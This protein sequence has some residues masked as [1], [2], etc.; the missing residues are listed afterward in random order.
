MIAAAS[1]GIVAMVAVSAAQ[2]FNFGNMMNPSRWFNDRDRD[3]D[4]YGGYG[5]YGYGGGPYGW[6]GPYGGYGPYGGWGGGPWG[7]YGGYPSTI[8]VSPP[9]SGSQSAPPPPRLPE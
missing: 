8:V 1:L 5:P 9:T 7:G 6:G 4:Y 2:A 3:R